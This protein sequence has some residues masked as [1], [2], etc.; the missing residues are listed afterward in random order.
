MNSKNSILGGIVLMILLSAGLVPL[1]SAQRVSQMER[2]KAAY[3]AITNFAPLYV[4]IDRGF[5]KEQNIDVDMEKVA[6]GTEAMASL[7]RGHWMREELESPQP[8]LTPLIRNLIFGSSP[9]QRFSLI[10]EA[11]Q[12]SLYAK[13]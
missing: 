7:R 2:V 10:R 8:P 4:A 3:V 12:S 9:P 11:Q 13:S 6:S 5:M 1:A